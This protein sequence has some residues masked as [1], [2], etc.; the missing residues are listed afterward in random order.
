MKM[1]RPS[2]RGFVWA[3]LSG[4]LI[5]YRF[6]GSRS[7]ETPVEVLGGTRG[8]LVV[9][10]YTG[11]NRI[12]DV[13]GR[14][15]AGC[16]AHVRRK[17]FDAL[18]AGSIEARHAL[19]LILDVYRVE[20]EAR[21]RGIVR[22]DEHLR[23]RRTR[24]REAMD[25]LRT[26]LFDQ[27]GQHAPKS[28]IGEAVRCALNQWNT[29]TAFLDDARIPVDNNAS[30]RALRVIASLV[31]LCASSSNAGNLERVIVARISTRATATRAFA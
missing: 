15:R 29:L 23:L 4:E 17:F 16:I 19:D 9:D 2:K 6:A 3:F 22:S 5:A 7:G 28:P 21:A 12:I 10:A 8:T 27:Q 1:Q 18:Q 26:W 20:H 13:D 25:H 30:E 14:T 24:S 31:S 11:Y